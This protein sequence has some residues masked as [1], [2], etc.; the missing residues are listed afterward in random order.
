MVDAT[1]G[2]A[3]GDVDGGTN[4]GG[5]PVARLGAHLAALAPRTPA[6]ARQLGVT[7]PARV[8]GRDAL[9]ALPVTRKPELM[10]MQA[11]APPY[12]GWLPDGAVSPRTFVSPGPVHEPQPTGADPY[13]AAAALRAAGFGAGDVVVNCFGYHGTPGGFILDEGLRAL[14]ATV[15][16]AGPGNTDQTVATLGALRPVGY[17]GTP[18][19]LKVLLDRA[20]E[21]GTDLSSI[22]RALVSGGALFPSLRDGYAG[23]GVSVLQAYATADAGVIAHETMANGAL[24]PGMAVSDRMVVE[25]VTPGTGDPVGEGEVGELVVTLLSETWPLLR[26]GTGDLTRWI[27]AP[28]PGGAPGRIAGWMGRADQRTKVK[29]MFVD[30]AQIARV[31]KAHPNVVRA[32]LVVAREGEGDAMV[33][34]VVGSGAGEKIDPGAVA[35]TLRAETG[36]RGAVEIVDALPADGIVIEDARD[37]DG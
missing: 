35:A 8:T 22:T 34:R 20:A 21:A 30:P 6:L 14:G 33:L 36:L 16:P 31:V 23:R 29:G 2:H 5:D 25:I 3:N 11:D 19:F 28:S 26:F 18:D 15:F 24:D 27:A 4:R 37:Y 10:A 1:T 32:R 12:G 13:G 7:D 17:V 9:A